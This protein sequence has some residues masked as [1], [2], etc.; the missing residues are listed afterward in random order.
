MKLAFVSNL[1]PPHIL[2][3]YER[4]CALVRDG[5]VQRGHRVSVLTSDHGVAGGNGV[6]GATCDGVYRTLRLTCPF[7]RPADHGR[8]ARWRATV[9]NRR[10]ARAF[11]EAERPDLV[12]V[13]SQLRLSLGAALAAR[14][15]GLPVAY[16]FND[17][18]PLGYAA[19]PF[20][21]Q[22]RGLARFALDRGALPE[23]TWSRLDLGRVTCIS[24]SLRD[25]LVAG[26]VPVGHAQ[27]IYQCVP[28]EHRFAPR[29]DLGGLHDPARVLFL[30][31]LHAYKGV[32]TLIDA[33]GRLLAG[34]RRVRLTVA[35]AGPEPYT[36]RLRALAEPIAGAVTF[37]GA[38]PPA[39]LAALYRE[40][41]LFAFPSLGVEAFGLTFLE[42]MASGLPVVA[43]TG[44]GH[45]E[46]LVDGANSLTFPA[47]DAPA[48]AAALARVLDDA[49]LRRRLAE[50]GVATV[51]ERFTT[52]RYVTEL[53]AFLEKAVGA[54]AA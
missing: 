40:H 33:V 15:L 22:P 38:V 36:A 28:D 23:L 27:I 10:V 3:G 11:F 51:R 16:T 34:G 9:H 5:L 48:L 53:E 26:G 12:F 25:R 6:E 17:E 50:A 49:A 42:A 2:G 44:G 14:D 18:H 1:Y 31:Q 41:D 7:D 13:W 39:D 4:L 8:P 21:L 29:A 35:G 46:A 20:T 43:S 52:A 47:E 37:L 24:R 32:H 45:S 54:H 19:P 30:G